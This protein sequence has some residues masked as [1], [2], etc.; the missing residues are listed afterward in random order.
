MT[1]RGSLNLGAR[2]E[3]WGWYTGAI[4]SLRDTMFSGPAPHRVGG[5]N[6][7]NTEPQFRPLHRRRSAAV[8]A[9]PPPA[10]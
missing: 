9:V 2:L 1:V 10:P 4:K 8:G 3:G 6:Q 7:V 5:Q